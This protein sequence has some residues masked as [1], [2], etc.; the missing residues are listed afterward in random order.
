[1]G[2]NTYAG[3]DVTQSHHPEKNLVISGAEKS[4][5]SSRR[6]YL[7]EPEPDAEPAKPTS[8]PL[9]VEIFE[10]IRFEVVPIFLLGFPGTVSFAD[11][12]VVNLPSR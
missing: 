12:I 2:E 1:L 9:S 5:E 6:H 11:L 3:C 10:S 7:R 8:E 4:G